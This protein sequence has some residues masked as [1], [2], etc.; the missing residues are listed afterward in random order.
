LQAV[1]LRREAALAGGVDDQ[2]HLALV[3]AQLDAL[4]TDGLCLE[5]PHVGLFHRFLRSQRTLA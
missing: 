2:Q 3:A 5:A 4:A 1:E